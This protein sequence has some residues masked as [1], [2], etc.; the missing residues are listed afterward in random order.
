MNAHHRDW[1]FDRR[2]DQSHRRSEVAIG[3][4][5]IYLR[6]AIRGGNWNNGTQAGVFALNVNNSPSNV[7]N[8][9]S[10]RVA[11]HKAVA[12][13][14]QIMVCWSVLMTSGTQSLP[15]PVSGWQNT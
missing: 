4:C 1:S 14:E 5:P 15:R 10:L 9:I 2:L 8:N 3:L 6:A 7:N 12:R 13:I 11:K